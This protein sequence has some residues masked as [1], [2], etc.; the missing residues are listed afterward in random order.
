MFYP[1]LG[2]SVESVWY[3]SLASCMH[4]SHPFV[5]AATIMPP[6]MSM[7][8]AKKREKKDAASNPLPLFRCRFG[9]I[10]I[11]MRTVAIRLYLIK[12]VQTLTN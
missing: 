5:L 9:G 10:Q 8:A 11:A 6:T 7:A 4:N 2:S 3:P 1:L 12:I